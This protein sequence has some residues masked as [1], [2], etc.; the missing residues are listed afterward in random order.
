MLTHDE[1]EAI[2]PLVYPLPPTTREAFLL[3][4]SSALNGSPASGPGTAYRVARD[5]LPSFF[6]PPEPPRGR[7][8]HLN[9]RRP[10]PHAA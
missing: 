4:V 3:A 6:T 8:A 9:V 5:L 2:W 1:L 7:P 10:R